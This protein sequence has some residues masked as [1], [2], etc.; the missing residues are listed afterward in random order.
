MTVQ[1]DGTLAS[2]WAEYTF[3]AGERLSHCG[4]DAFH[5]VRTPAGWKIVSLVDTRRSDS[6]P[7]RRR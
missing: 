6:C 4:V 3:Y 5:L 7:E 1:V 2:V